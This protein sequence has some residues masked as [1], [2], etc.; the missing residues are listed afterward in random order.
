VSAPAPPSEPAPDDPAAIGDDARR[1][2]AEPPPGTGRAANPLRFLADSIGYGRRLFAAHGPLVVLGAEAAGAPAP[3]GVGAAASG[4]GAL[5]LACG[6]ELARQVTTQHEVFHKYPLTLSLYPPRPVS[7]RTAPLQHFLVGLFGVNGDEHRQQR[8]LML[9]AFHRQRVEAYRDDMVALTDAELA[10][11]RAD[12]RLD[13]AA[14]MRRLT[15]RIATKTLFGADVGE[16]GSAAGP[17]IQEA[18]ALLAAPAT[19]RA[20][21]DEPGQPYHRLLDVAGSFDAELRGLI[22]RKRAAGGDAGDVL[23]ELIRARDAETG[24]AL[25]EDE[26]LGHTGV[27]FAAGHE[28]SANALT[29][30]LFLLAQHPAVAADLHDELHGVLRG[31]A[32]T[33]AQLARLPLLDRVLKESL[34]VLTPVPWNARVAA[35]PTELGGYALPAGTRVLVSIYHTHHLPAL[36]PRP[37]AFDPGRWATLTPGPWEYMPFSAGPRLCLG[38]AFATMELKL[39]LAVL[40]Q[41]HRLECEPRPVIDRH[42]LIVLA[43][44]AGLPMLV[45]PQDRRFGDGVGGVRGNVREMVELP[46]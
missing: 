3:A 45:R 24:L 36:Y 7:A 43:P 37:E 30:T 28:T 39:V 20:P 25:T 27:L 33:A 18:L 10:Q 1:T 13:V 6:P 4:E 35:C 16:R 17:L 46:A 41:R 11:W 23:S 40:L 21:R 31:A 29:W 32:P 22:A 15:L 38:A 8:R 26:L 2:R 5:V 14:A 44:K 12:E 9:P 34:R 19:T 42:G